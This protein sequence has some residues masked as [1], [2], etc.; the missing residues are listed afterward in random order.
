MKRHKSLRNSSLMQQTIEELHKY[1]KPS[2]PLVDVN[3][4]SLICLL[5]K[6]LYSFSLVHDSNH[7]DL[8]Y[9]KI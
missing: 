5:A 6:W 3:C 2:V 4:F 9:Y 1:F 8:L 7:E